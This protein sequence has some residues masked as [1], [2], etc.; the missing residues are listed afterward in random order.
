MAFPMRVAVGLLVLKCVV[1]LQFYLQEGQTLCFGEN[2]APNSKVLGEYTVAA[3]QGH[4]P[5]DI[6]VRD[7]AENR[8]IYQRNDI[9]HGKFAFIAPFGNQAPNVHSS[10]LHRN[11]DVH[12]NK[13]AHRSDSHDSYGSHHAHDDHWKHEDHHDSHDDHWRH[14]DEHGHHNAPPEH[15]HGHDWD[16]HQHSSGGSGDS[17]HEEHPH[18]QTRRLLSYE[19]E[20][21][22]RNYEPQHDHDWNSHHGGDSHKSEQHGHGYSALGHE[23]SEHEHEHDREH[24]HHHDGDKLEKLDHMD[25]HDGEHGDM[26]EEWDMDKYDGLHD[27]DME[28]DWEENEKNA[29]HIDEEDEEEVADELF[30]ERKFE[31]CV[32]SSSPNNALRRRVR[33]NMRHGK[34]ALDYTRLAKTEH[35]S[36]L[37]L[38]LRI[39]H[40]E[41]KELNVE[42]DHA[43]QM[44][45]ALRKLNEHTNRRVVRYA[46][47]SL[48]VLVGVS[49]MQ[50]M[51]TR[52]FFRKKKLI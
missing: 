35:M 13:H 41:L 43:R 37:E 29:P 1:G 6:I 52:S 5:V 22:H 3:G 50:S 26:D 48:V 32:S 40:D 9:N 46:V 28:R 31:I 11:Q 12:H 51:F 38:T 14:D 30:K 25:A 24:E 39:V 19:S 15:D 36:S 33:L 16:S 20:Y 44:E 8:T 17:H 34:A 4:M 27:E 42:L 7:L 21:G 2:I 47:L 18:R 49:S 10:E 23:H 45:E